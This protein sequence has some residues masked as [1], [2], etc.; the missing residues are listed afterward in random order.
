MTPM[1]RM[2]PEC[3]EDPEAYL[4]A[5]KAD[6]ETHFSDR[7]KVI[8]A[9]AL[10]QNVPRPGIM[11]R[12]GPIGDSQLQDTAEIAF[13]LYLFWKGLTG[14][15]VAHQL[16]SWAYRR[17]AWHRSPTCETGEY[18][19]TL[20]AIDYAIS[21][22]ALIRNDYSFHPLEVDGFVIREIGIDWSDGDGGP[23]SDPDSPQTIRGLGNLAADITA[24]ADEFSFA[25]D[26]EAAVLVQELL[27]IGKEIVRVTSVPAGNAPRGP[28]G[29]DR[30]QRR[31]AAEQHDAGSPIQVYRNR[32]PE[33]I[34][35]ERS[36]EGS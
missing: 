34:P 13:E 29:I 22:T 33:R 20:G 10:V 12:M 3:Y 35:A 25:D 21:W 27:R 26:P 23:L 31:T 7:L 30:A 19:P 16:R 18:D 9:G 5:V 2:T 11:L 14:G 17:F 1:A 6:L 32:R 28:Y 4:D 24:D 8:K 36:P 15:K